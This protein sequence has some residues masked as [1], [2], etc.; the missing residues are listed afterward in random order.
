[1]VK[2]DVKPHY[3]DKVVGYHGRITTSLFSYSCVHSHDDGDAAYD[4]ALDLLRTLGADIDS[5][6]RRESDLRKVRTMQ[7]NR[8]FL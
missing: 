3:L 7:P 1:M 2:I 4:C 5:R 6:L 8:L